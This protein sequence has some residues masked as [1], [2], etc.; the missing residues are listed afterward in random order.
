MRPVKSVTY[1]D[2]HLRERSSRIFRHVDWWDHPVPLLSPQTLG[3]V[4]AGP[5]E[6]DDRRWCLERLLP[7]LSLGGVPLFLCDLKDN[8]RLYLGGC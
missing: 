8:T 3:A 2:E 4:E 1:A 5:R 7:L 6:H